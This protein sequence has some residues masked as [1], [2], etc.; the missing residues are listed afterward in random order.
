VDIFGVDVFG[1]GLDTFAVDTDVFVVGADVFVVGA[2]VFVVGADVVV[3][4]A[5]V[6]VTVVTLL[7]GG[8]V[9]AGVFAR[10]F[11]AD[12]AAFVDRRW[13]LRVCRGGA[14]C[15]LVSTITGVAK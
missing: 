1:V 8:F 7:G 6:F 10:P 15:D 4:R 11:V 13:P 14:S 12:V 9:V 3:L 2:D 5:A